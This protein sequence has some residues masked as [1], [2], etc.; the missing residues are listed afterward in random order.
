MQNL[1]VE[2][3]IQKNKKTKF[4]IRKELEESIINEKVTKTQRYKKKL[5]TSQ[6]VKMRRKLFKFEQIIKNKKSDIIWL[7]YHQDKY[8]KDLKKNNYL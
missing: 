3:A 4:K 7:T 5:T 6:Q 8:F 2:E 1:D